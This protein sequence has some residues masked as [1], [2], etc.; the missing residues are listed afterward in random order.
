[1]SQGSDVLAPPSS[2]TASRLRRSG[3]RHLTL[4][5]L[6]QPS[7]YFVSSLV[8]L[9]S[10]FWNRSWFALVINGDIGQRC[11]CDLDVFALVS[12]TLGEYF[13]FDGDG[14]VANFHHA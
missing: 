9:P 10:C 5:L 3:P 14:G 13:Y 2:E 7:D 4:G 8:N 11:L 6:R 1:M 12:E